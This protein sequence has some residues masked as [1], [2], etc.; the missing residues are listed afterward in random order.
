MTGNWQVFL[1]FGSEYVLSAFADID[2]SLIDIFIKH[3]RSSVWILY[4]SRFTRSLQNL[5][6]AKY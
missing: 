6:T 4:V 1:T 3:K 5:K 2:I